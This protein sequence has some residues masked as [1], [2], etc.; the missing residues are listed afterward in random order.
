M[1]IAGFQGVWSLGRLCCSTN[2]RCM[3]VYVLS[4]PLHHSCSQVLRARFQGCQWRRRF[5]CSLG[6]LPRVGGP[7]DQ[8]RFTCRRPRRTSRETLQELHLNKCTEIPAEAWQQ[9]RPGS[10]P[11]LRTCHGV[12]PDIESSLRSTSASSWLMRIVKV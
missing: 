6:P 8:T 9:L 12:P 4:R 10:F 1:C 11:R 2:K 3:K 5:A 7:V